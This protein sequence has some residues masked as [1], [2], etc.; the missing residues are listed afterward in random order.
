[1]NFRLV[2]PC[3]EIEQ[4]YID[5]INDWVKSGEKI[6]PYAS[7]REGQNY[8]EL[9]IKWKREASNEAYEKDLVPATLYFLIDESGK[10]HG[11]T[12]IRHKL[13]ENLI[14]HGGH[15]GYGV[16]PSERKRG[17]ATKML[18]LALPIAKELG[19]DKILVTCDKDNIASAKTILRNNGILENEISEGDN[20]TQRYWIQL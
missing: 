18:S 15:I 12:H 7:R 5:Y 20:I 13:N 1:M 6:V 10:I 3:L 19:I 2:E 17:I 8:R 14:K 4:A 16:R 11:S 9:L